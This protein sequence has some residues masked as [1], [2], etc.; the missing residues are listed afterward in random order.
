MGG[1]YLRAAILFFWAL[2]LGAFARF[3]QA[4][5]AFEFFEDLIASEWIWAALFMAV[6]SLSLGAA[7]ARMYRSRYLSQALIAISWGWI[8][9]GFAAVNWQSTAVPVLVGLSIYSIFGLVWVPLVGVFRHG[10]E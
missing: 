9:G 2:W 1:E 6:A 8:A 3:D 4:P 5:D 7:K 10:R